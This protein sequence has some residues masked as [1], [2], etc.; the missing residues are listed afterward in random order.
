MQLV[1][2][3]IRTEDTSETEPI[4]SQPSTAE[5]L[6]ESSSSIEIIVGVDSCI[7]AADPSVSEIHEDVALVRGD[8]P[9]CRICLDTEGFYCLF[10]FLVDYWFWWPAIMGNT[11]LPSVIEM[12]NITVILNRVFQWLLAF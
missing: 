6:E 12:V 11:G 2:H 1:Q 10:V 7:A 4:L 9:Q 8:Q 3:D 5:R